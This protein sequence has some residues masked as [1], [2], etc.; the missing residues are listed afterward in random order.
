MVVVMQIGAPEA[1]VENVI[2]ILSSKGFDVLR[3]SGQQQ[4]VLC[5]IGVQREFEIRQVRVLEGVADVHRITSP[6]KLAS[7]TWQNEN[8]VVAVGDIEIGGI[9]VVLLRDIEPMVHI[10]AG[11][12]QN[13]SLLR[14]VG[15]TQKPVLLR[16]NALASVSEWLVS[17]D[18]ILNGG[19]PNVVLCEGAP[20]PLAGAM[21]A[22]LLRSVD[23]AVIP[24]IKRN[25]HLPII[26][27]PECVEGG[28]SHQ[29]SLARAAVAAGADG[30]LLEG[31]SSFERGGESSIA[32]LLN[33]LGLIAGA[34]GRSLRGIDAK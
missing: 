16:R 17:A 25:S 32:E 18:I 13:E 7:R 27:D 10:S 9:D 19:N 30:V 29:Y 24:E 12:M 1:H 21:T 5:A 26:L 33:A 4:T 22:G 28:I 31:A 23:I 15:E 2:E 34:V 14:E 3:T 6:Y 20:R 11:N 8:S